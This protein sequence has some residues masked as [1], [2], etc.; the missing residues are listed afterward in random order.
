VAR[1]LANFKGD[2]NFERSPKPFRNYMPLIITGV[3]ARK[4][5]LGSMFL[6]KRI[7]SLCL[8]SPEAP[9]PIQSLDVAGTHK[10]GSSTI[11]CPEEDRM[12]AKMT[13]HQ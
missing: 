11:T 10:K 4:P 2:I 5:L 7:K 12:V 13:S 1:A 3:R 6:T 8:N 9:A